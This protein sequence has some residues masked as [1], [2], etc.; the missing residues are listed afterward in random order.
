MGEV[1]GIA[2][3]LKTLEGRVPLYAFTNSNPTHMR[4]VFSAYA[5]TLRP[6]RKVFVSSDLGFRKPE[7]PAFEAISATIG[8]PL[9]RILFFDDTLVNVEGA[10]AIGMQAVHVTS[11]QDV[12]HAV[13]ELA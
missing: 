7:R 13:R 8:V 9:E 5:E 12:A 11:V 6:F 4:Y 10:Q 3:I 1:P 2:P